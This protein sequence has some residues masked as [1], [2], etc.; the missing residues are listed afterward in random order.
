M[1]VLLATR[2]KKKLVE[3]DRILRDADV[4][5]TLIGLDDVPPFPEVLESGATFIENALLKAREA[6]RVTGL[7]TIAD[8]SGL[9]VDA[10][11][12]MPG[13]LSAR[14]AGGHG[15]DVANLRL[16]LD[17]MSAVPAER[18]GAS[19]ECAAVFVM[20]GE[21]EIVAQGSMSGTL[22]TEPRGSGGFGYDPIF[23]PTGSDRTTAE[24][25]A[26]EKDAISHRGAALR[27]LASETSRMLADGFPSSGSH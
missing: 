12:G 22:L 11:N 15:D 24:M 23:A 21:F 5:I 10:L 25:S 19:F 1:N 2:N 16:V 14:W 13:V 9:C 17:Q 8:D 26:V 7:A 27:D 18:R 3:L 4:D 6:A 20:P